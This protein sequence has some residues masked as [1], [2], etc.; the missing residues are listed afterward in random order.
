MVYTE[1]APPDGVLAQLF[2]RDLAVIADHEGNPMAL[3]GRA[4]LR[5][6]H[7]GLPDSIVLRQHRFHLPKLDPLPSH[8]DLAVHAT[9]KFVHIIVGSPQPVPCAVQNLREDRCAR[10]TNEA[11]TRL[12]IIR[13]VSA[14]QD[15]RCRH[16]LSFRRISEQV[17]L[18][19]KVNSRTRQRLAYRNAWSPRRPRGTR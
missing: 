3:I 17:A 14:R 11:R 7:D 13:P 2:L 5:R 9:G 15:A 12:E 8:L 10:I 4:R 6:K 19:H 16:A 18:I 1:L